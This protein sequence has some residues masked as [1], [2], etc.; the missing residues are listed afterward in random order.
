M[1]KKFYSV[2]VIIYSAL[3]I[4]IMINYKVP[5][6]DVNKDITLVKKQQEESSD[7]N[8]NNTYVNTKETIKNN[9][10]N[11][12]KNDIQVKGFNEYSRSKTRKI[13]DDNLNET[14]KLA[15]E[16]SGINSINGEFDSFNTEQRKKNQVIKVPVDEIVSCLSLSEKGKLFTI[17]RKLSNEDYIK[18][19]EY[20]GYKNQ[21][22]GMR[23]ALEIIEAKLPQEEVEEVKTI[24]SKFMDME[25]IE[26]SN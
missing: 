13:V 18:F 25:V 4:Y 23:K 5:N 2:I 7:K 8:S 19:Q 17:S 11:A 12:T 9:D 20:L 14:Y 1:N 26:N 3:C 24:L 10:S 22:I 16:D 6:E 21:K 15:H